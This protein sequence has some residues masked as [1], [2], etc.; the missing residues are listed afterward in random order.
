MPL[1]T[2]A[3]PLGKDEYSRLMVLSVGFN[4]LYALKFDDVERRPESAQ[5]VLQAGLK[6]KRHMKMRSLPAMADT[7]LR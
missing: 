4:A 7:R 5:T 2:G 1:Q 6:L 3:N